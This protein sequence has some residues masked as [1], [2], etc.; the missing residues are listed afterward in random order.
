MSRQEGG[1]VDYTPSWE[2]GE[3]HLVGAKL[4]PDASDEG[5]WTGDWRWLNQK[6]RWGSRGDRDLEFGDA[7]PY[8]PSLG[9]AWKRPFQWLDARYEPAPSPHSFVRP[10]SIDPEA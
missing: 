8:G 5:E 4:I 6:G 1:L 2:Q 10:T 7:G 9:D 3:H